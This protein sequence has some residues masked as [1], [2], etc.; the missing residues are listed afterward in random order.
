MTHHQ[1][2]F[3]SSIA[4]VLVAAL[5]AATAF[6][7]VRENDQAHQAATQAAVRDK[8]TLLRSRLE[9]QLYGNILLVR[10]LVSVFAAKPDLDQQDFARFAHPL[11]SGRSQ[12]R[13]LGAAPDMVIR[14]V[15]PLAGNEAALGLDYRTHP[16]QRAAAERARES[17]E[18]ILAGPL[19]MV[20]GGVGI[21]ARF[22]VFLDD[23]NGERRFWG[24]LSAAIDAERLVR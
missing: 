17:G 19:A 16:V 22:P 14:A 18:I 1:R 20:Q 12:L 15:Y 4:V 21:I 10:G 7:V 8:L 5:L 6:F 23:E 9:G 13:N 2:R 3:L 24:L 11:F